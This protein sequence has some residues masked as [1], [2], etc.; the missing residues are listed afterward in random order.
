[1]KTVSTFIFALMMVF[2][3]N[4]SAWAGSGSETGSTNLNEQ[5]EPKSED[6]PGKPD[7]FCGNGVAGMIIVHC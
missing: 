3:M 6:K 1:M 7:D 5:I 4:S 2:A